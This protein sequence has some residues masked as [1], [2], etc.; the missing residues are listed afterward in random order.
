M[1][2]GLPLYCDLSTGQGA[3]TGWVG[4]VRMAYDRSTTT[5]K[6]Q[7][8]IIYAYRY[9]PLMTITMETI[10]AIIIMIQ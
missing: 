10:I 6:Q 9:N 5:A 3:G 7:R 4:S 1:L 8:L 2:E